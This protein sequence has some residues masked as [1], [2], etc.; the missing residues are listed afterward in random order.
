MRLHI[1]ARPKVS[2]RSPDL[3]LNTRAQNS[4]T[5]SFALI[6]VHDQRDKRVAI[7]RKVTEPDIRPCWVESREEIGGRISL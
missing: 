5:Y 6:I 2:L 3:R 7:G 1:G 4:A